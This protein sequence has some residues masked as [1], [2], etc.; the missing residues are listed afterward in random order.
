MTHHRPQ[1]FALAFAAGMLA[2]VACTD[3][4][5]NDDARREADAA[6]EKTAK[7]AAAAADKAAEM[8]EL[9]RDKTRAFVTSPQVKQDA[10]AVKDAIQGAGAAAVATADDAAITLA[11]T[12][13][14]ARDAELSASR[15]DVE[16]KGGVVHLAGPAPS[17]AA[18]ARA[19]ELAG[20]VQG[21][22]TVDN[23]LEVKTM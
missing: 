15:I 18:K 11:V 20:S 7:A 2:L 23:A 17:A 10:A 13:A 12:R 3:R 14:L 16:T 5:S 9:A 6:V 22:K 1:P 21:V 19:G 4:A 8:A